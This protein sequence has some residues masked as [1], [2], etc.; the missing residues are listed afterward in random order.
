MFLMMTGSLNDYISQL[1]LLAFFAGYPLIYT[2]VNFLATKRHERTSFLSNKWVQLLPF[3]YALIGTLFIGLFLKSISP[4]F[5]LKNIAEQFQSPFLEG[6]AIMSVLFWIPA[7]TKK[8]VF[9]LF[10]SLPFFFLLINHF[11]TQTTSSSGRFVIDNDMKMYTISFLLNI[12]ALVFIYAL[13]YCLRYFRIY[14]N[15]TVN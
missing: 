1:Q 14:K 10:H 8:P 13:F 3:A 5:S 6:W 4:D 15:T 12:V 7:F 9:S 2:L 11:F